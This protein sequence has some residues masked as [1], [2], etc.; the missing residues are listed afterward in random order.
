V[1]QAL[2]QLGRRAG[3]R[4]I[5]A[6]GSEAKVGAARAAGAAEVVVGRGDAIWPAL[7]PLAP[8]GFDLICDANGA[9]TLRGS[10]AHLAPGGRLVVYGFHS[11]FG[12][13]GGGRPSWPS[14]AWGWLRTPRFD[15]LAMTERNRSVMAFN[16]SFLGDRQDLLAR[17]LGELL[18][19]V[20]RG[21]LAPPALTEHGF[22]D[23]V[24]A[25][26]ALGSGNTT[27]KLV[28]VV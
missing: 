7:E 8:R 1:G 21:E 10:F 5:G 23:C 12:R 13:G 27:G 9:A 4:V 22:E 25:Q 24:G 20:A 17:G 18:G 11:M 19:W 14:L 2:C 6:V 3:A 26:R 16:L 28:L 15:P